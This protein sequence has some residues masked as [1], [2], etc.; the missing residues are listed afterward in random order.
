MTTN[1]EEIGRE[2]GKLVSEKQ[3]AY[4]DSYGNSGK[5]LSILFP[6]GVKP[7]HYQELLAICRVIDKLFR[8]ANDPGYGGES[9]WGDI[10]GYAL[11]RLGKQ[12]ADAIKGNEI[13]FF[14]IN[15]LGPIDKA[16]L[17]AFQKPKRLDEWEINKVIEFKTSGPV[18]TCQI[19]AMN[20]QDLR[21]AGL[22][23]G[24][25]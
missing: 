5:I 6:N 3:K 24:G 15:D 9:P 25:C 13:D 19:A 10:C 20:Q 16:S 11:L 23:L 4:G 7:E 22:G 17:E 8:L 21:D 2:I 12:K 14:N 18:E 1:Y